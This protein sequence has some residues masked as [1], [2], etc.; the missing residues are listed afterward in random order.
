MFAFSFG[1]CCSVSFYVSFQACDHVSEVML[2]MLWWSRLKTFRCCFQTGCFIVVYGA[3]TVLMASLPSP[4]FHGFA[5]Q[6]RNTKQSTSTPSE[7]KPTNT[8]YCCLL[9]GSCENIVSKPSYQYPPPTIRYFLRRLERPLGSPT[10]VRPRNVPA[11]RGPGNRFTGAKGLQ[12]YN[13]PPLS[14][15]NDSSPTVDKA[16]TFIT[17]KKLQPINPGPPK[18]GLWL[19]RHFLRLPDDLYI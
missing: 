16:R 12:G 17:K 1:F 15:R 9:F 8:C 6:R 13:T 4:R 7:P 3:L 14:K 19:Y 11:L 10:P 18:L 2:S 5:Q